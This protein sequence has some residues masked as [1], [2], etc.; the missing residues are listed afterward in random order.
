M[1]FC[2]VLGPEMS[3]GMSD[4]TAYCVPVHT[5]G[6]TELWVDRVH[7]H[8]YMVTCFHCSVLCVYHHHYL[9]LFLCFLTKSIMANAMIGFARREKMPLFQGRN[10]P[11]PTGD[12][13]A[14]LMS[15]HPTVHD[16]PFRPKGKYFSN[17]FSIISWSFLY[18]LIFPIFFLLSFSPYLLQGEKSISLKVLAPFLKMTIRLMGTVGRM[19]GGTL[20]QRGIL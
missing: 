13:A 1:C 7:H 11:I 4:V 19:V 20:Y 8:R 16:L 18:F 15:D 14:L 9:S 5:P 10:T 17:S 6:S 3:P 2:L 12:A